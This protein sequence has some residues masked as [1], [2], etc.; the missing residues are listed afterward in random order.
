M[1]AKRETDDW[2][3]IELSPEHTVYSLE[4]LNCGSI[5]YIYLL[6]YNKVGKGSPSTLLT[7]STK[8]GK[9]QLP[10]ERDFIS[11]NATSLQLNLY[12]WPDGGCPIIEFSIMYRS[13]IS[14]NWIC[15]AKPST[16]LVILLCRALGTQKWILVSAGAS[17]DKLLVQDLTPA[18]WY[19]LK[20]A[21]KN[22]A[23]EA[24]GLFNFAT[25]TMM[26]GNKNSI[27]IHFVLMLLFLRDYPAAPKRY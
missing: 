12:N 21:A 13:G 19:Q 25:T 9:P 17:G 24:N 7:V 3:S 14:S 22:D 6:A 23:G 5:Y 2:I 1:S 26:G 4:D 10:K 11:T 15:V 20:V 8:G 27:E 18:T 16:L